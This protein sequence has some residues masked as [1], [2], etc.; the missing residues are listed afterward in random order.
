MRKRGLSKVPPLRVLIIGAGKMG[1]AHAAVFKTIPRVEIVGIA[2]RGG[3]TAGRLA[4]EIEGCQA[5]SD[6]KRLADETRPDAC[7]VAV[8]HANNLK[9]TAEVIDGGFHVLAEKPVAFW[10]REVH[11]LAKRAQERNVVAMA[12]M[13]RRFYPSVLGAIETVR[14]YSRIVSVHALAADP[15]RIYRAQGMYDAVVYDSW[16]R[17]NTLHLIDLL[18]LAAG[19]V[20]RIHVE[21]EMHDG[22]GERSIVA[23]LRFQ[24]GALGSFVLHSGPGNLWEMRVCGEGIEAQLGPLERGTVRV[25]DA[26]PRALPSSDDGSGLKPGLR[27]QALAFVEGIQE[28]GVIAPPASSLEDHARSIELAENL[29]GL[30]GVTAGGKEAGEPREMSGEHRSIACGVRGLPGE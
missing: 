25:G 29:E 26:V 9:V 14:F 19:E 13:N 30:F 23:A 8:S 11:A 10:S 6:W 12:A 17:T 28:L 15:V 3:E 16:L 21:R 24:R 27:A 20:E 4:A 18:R 1:R 22:M 7:V 5:G 2:S